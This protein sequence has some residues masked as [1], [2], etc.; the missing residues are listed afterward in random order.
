MAQESHSAKILV[1][2]DNAENRALAKAA[3]EDEGY[4][5][6]LAASGEEGLAAFEKSSPDCVL[7]DVRMPGMDGF[8]TCARLRALPRGKETPVVFLTAL[9]DID[10]FDDAI[11]AGADDFLTKPINPAELAV[12]VGT[13]VR[14]SR[15]SAELREHTLLV[16]RQ[17]DDLMRLQL[18]KEQL[19]AFVV[20]DLKNPLNGIDLHAQVLARSKDL[21]ERARSSVEQIR[22]DVRSLMRLIL[23]LLDISK[24]EQGTIAPRR[25]AVD[26]PDLVTHLFEVFGLRARSRTVE[27]VSDLRAREV[28]ADRDLLQR[29][30]ENLIDNAIR[31]TPEETEVTLTART[32]DGAVEI[33]VADRGAGVPAEMREKVF[34]RFVQIESGGPQ[35]ARTGRGLGLT[36]C[37]LVVE[38]HGGR[39]WLDD[40]GPGAAFVVV[41]PNVEPS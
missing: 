13:A 9:R 35:V 31:H 17:R 37:K 25:E 23:N 15:M 32:V 27:L 26:L 8:A 10:T 28:V 20:H 19:M 22:D 39:I 1:V 4:T 7:L 38:A 29:L 41:L 24:S 16:R 36:F 12:R 40:A 11:R 34:D 18:Q 14:L 33:R 5:V 30:L 21:P 2:D 3:L 6:F